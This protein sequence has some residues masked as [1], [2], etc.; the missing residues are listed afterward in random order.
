MSG[1]L[2]RRARTFAR[3][4][5]AEHLAEGAVGLMAVRGDADES[6]VLAGGRR[7]EDVVVGLAPVEGGD[8]RGGR[9]GNHGVLS[10]R[11][12]RVR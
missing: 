6:G 5:Q 10:K 12:G 9:G 8:R 4:V 2:D 11:E 3:R 7:D 1:C